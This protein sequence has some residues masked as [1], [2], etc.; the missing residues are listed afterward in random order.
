MYNYLV[1]DAG[2]RDKWF[3]FGITTSERRKMKSIPDSDNLRFCV[4]GSFEPVKEYFQL[5]MEEKEVKEIIRC[6]QELLKRT[7]EEK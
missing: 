7:K 1:P 5:N 4:H 3:C 6:L 2:G